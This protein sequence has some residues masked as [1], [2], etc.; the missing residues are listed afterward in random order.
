MDHRPCHP[1]TEC[2]IEKVN[3]GKMFTCDSG[4]CIKSILVCNNQND[5]GDNSDEKNCGK[6]KR[7]CASD[8]RH[9]V[10]PGAELIGNGFDVASEMQRGAVLDNSFLGEDCRLN[11]SREDRKVY[12]IPANIESYDF[13]VETKEDFKF[14]D[15]P[16]KTEPINFSSM[17]ASSSNSQSDSSLLVPIPIL[18]TL[19]KSRWSTNSESFKKTAK[20]SQEKDSK[21]F[22]LH[23]VVATSNFKTKSSDLYLSHNFMEFL[24]ALPLEYN[25]ALYRQVFQ[26][27]GTHYFSS[28]SLGGIYDLLYQYDREQLKTSGKLLHSNQ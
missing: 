13:K 4:R 5:C 24:S 3:C 18:F 16:A 20:A 23:Q 14:E 25:Y 15:M 10:I 8:R 21:F 28:G 11:R 17:S 1:A 6:I 7:V 12:R 22:R 19:H 27:F 9:A 26:V 2:R